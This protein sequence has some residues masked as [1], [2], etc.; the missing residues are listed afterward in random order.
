M[1]NSLCDGRY[2]GRLVTRIRFCSLAQVT[3][4]FITHLGHPVSKRTVQRRLHGQ[5]IYSRVAVQK[6][7]ISL[8]NWLRWRR[9]CTRT[10]N[11]TIPDNW[12]CLLFSDE[13]RFNDENVS[14]ENYV[15]ALSENL[16]DCV[17][18]IFGDRNRPFLF[19]HANAIAHTAR[20]TVAWLE[21]QDLSTIQWSSQSPD[22]NMIE[23]V[24]DFMGREIVGVMPVTRNDLTWVQLHKSW[25]NITVPYLHNLHNSLPRKV[26]AIIRGAGLPHKILI[27]NV[28][29]QKGQYLNMFHYSWKEYSFVANY[30]DKITF[31]NFRRKAA[32]NDIFQG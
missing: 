30:K 9:W 31:F 27:N 20:R 17:E 26:R 10:L 15:R 22:L 32:C 1:G 12:S 6:L 25:L 3:Q 5:V 16:L 21:Q 14:V 2:L 18:N 23:L 19:Q 24:W 28:F 8:E 11:W 7:D 29:S 13:S 4:E